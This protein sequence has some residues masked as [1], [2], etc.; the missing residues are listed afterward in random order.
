MEEVTSRI[1][2]SDH[3]A[4]WSKSTWRSRVRSGLRPL[5][6]EADLVAAGG[7]RTSGVDGH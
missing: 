4:R 3:D 6:P 5:P 1:S 7:D 2:V